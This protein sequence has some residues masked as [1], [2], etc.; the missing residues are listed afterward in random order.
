LRRTLDIAAAPMPSGLDQADAEILA[1]S[2]MSA[3]KRGCLAALENPAEGRFLIT[4]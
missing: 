1:L 3:A 2:A 4:F